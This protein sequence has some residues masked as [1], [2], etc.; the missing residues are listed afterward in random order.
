[1]NETDRQQVEAGCFA[2]AM[3]ILA[4]ASCIAGMAFAYILK[5]LQ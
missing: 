4:I 5:V 3:T 1:M 2:I